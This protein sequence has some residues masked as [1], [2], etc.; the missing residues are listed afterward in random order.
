MGKLSATRVQK[1]KPQPKEVRLSDG[2]GLVLR[3]RPSGVKSWLYYFRMPNN[4][5][6]Q[7]ITL[8]A[9]PDTSLDEA[10]EML[11]ELRKLIK[12][13]LDPR[14]V[15][16]AQTTENSQAITMQALFETWITFIIATKSC[17]PKWIKAHQGRWNGHLKQPLGNIL[18]RDITRAH[19]SRALQAMACQGIKEETRKALTTLNLVLDYGLNHHFIEQNHARLLKPK[20]FAASANRPRDRVLSLQEL[21]RLWI[22]IDNPGNT[23]SLSIVTTTAIKLLILTAVRRNEIATMQWTD[24][25]TEKGIW[26]IPAHKTKNQQ[27]HTVFL[28][29]LSIRLLKSLLPL[30]G[31]SSFVFDT[32]LNTRGHIHPDALTKAIRRLLRNDNTINADSTPPLADIKPFTVHDIRRSVATALG[33]LIKVQPHIIERM[34][35]HLPKR[36][37]RTYQRAL[38]ADEQKSAWLAWGEMV[39]HQVANYFENIIPIKKSIN[40]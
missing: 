18:A 28:S 7:Q 5:A 13:G 14:Q 11:P 23:L 40:Y 3:I 34:L 26:E 29:P 22:A 35:N 6:L 15:R 1:E 10:R 37:E 32:G 31:R 21:R 24:L 30:N 19:L 17:T 12:Q 36:L 27:A 8:G 16:A 25:N 38:Y 4:R 20:D 33:E 39:E 2:Q 9:Y